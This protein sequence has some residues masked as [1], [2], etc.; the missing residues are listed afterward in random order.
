MRVYLFQQTRKRN[1]FNRSLRASIPK[2]QGITPAEKPVQNKTRRNL[3]LNELLE[4]QVISEEEY[5]SCYD[6]DISVVGINQ[7]TESVNAPYFQDLVL[8]ELQ[9]MP[10]LNDYAYKGLK[11]YTTLDRRLNTVIQQSLKNR[12]PDSDIEVAIYVMNPK[13][14][15]VLNVIGERLSEKQ[16]QPGNRQRQAAGFGHQTFLYLTAL[17]NGFTQSTTFL[18]EPTTFYLSTVRIPPKT[19]KVFILIPIFP[20]FTPLPPATIST[21]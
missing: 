13:N 15:H 19:F 1:Q 6:Q 7:N 16:L 17:E 2:S 8:R 12:L 3:I 9:K 10:W 14:G 11:V 21:P 20:W 5:L 4:E 18:S